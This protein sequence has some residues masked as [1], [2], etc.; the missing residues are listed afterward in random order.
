MSTTHTSKTLPGCLMLLAVLVVTAPALAM[1]DPATGRWL[2]RDPIDYN[3]LGLFT[4]LVKEPLPQVRFA[5]TGMLGIA[6]EQFRSPPLSIPEHRARRAAKVSLLMIALY[7][8]PLRAGNLFNARNELAKI[9]AGYAEGANVY[10]FLGLRTTSHVDPSGTG[11]CRHFSTPLQNNV[12]LELCLFICDN[13]YVETGKGCYCLPGPF[14]YNV[15]EEVC[16]SDPANP[17]CHNCRESNFV[18]GGPGWIGVR[19]E[20]CTCDPVV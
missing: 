5:H 14:G 11:V 7:E 12:S 1:N 15:F 18:F 19:S 4:P 13:T 17:C 20:V 10:T 9:S 16:A 6:G 3:T 8:H 2:T